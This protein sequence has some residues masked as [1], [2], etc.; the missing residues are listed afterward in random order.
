MKFTHIRPNLYV[1]HTLG[2]TSGAVTTYP[3]REPE[4]TPVLLGL[5]YIVICISLLALFL[6][7]NAIDHSIHVKFKFGLTGLAKDKKKKKRVIP[8]S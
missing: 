3:S 6:L 4:Y 8:V 7:N 5:A 2:S 1:H